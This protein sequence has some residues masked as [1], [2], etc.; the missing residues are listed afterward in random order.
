MGARRH[1]NAR[2]LPPGAR[3]G[4]Y[5]P[6]IDSAEHPP[7]LL[8]EP[9]LRL[10]ES[11]RHLEAL[12]LG[13]AMRMGPEPCYMIRSIGADALGCPGVLFVSILVHGANLI[14]QC[15]FEDDGVL[16]VR[17]RVLHSLPELEELASV[18]TARVIAG[19]RA[20]AFAPPALEQA[21]EQDPI[22]VM[23]RVQD[24]YSGMTSHHPLLASTAAGLL[25]AH[26]DLRTWRQS[27]AALVAASADEL[28]HTLVTLS[29]VFSAHVSAFLDDVRPPPV[30]EVVLATH[31]PLRQLAL[32]PRLARPGTTLSSIPAL[33][34]IRY[35]RERQ[36]RRAADPATRGH[37]RL[38]LVEELSADGG[39]LDAQFGHFAQHFD[40]VRRLPTHA[41][42][43]EATFERLMRA[44]I[45]HIAAHGENTFDVGAG[46][47]HR[48][49]RF[50]PANIHDMRAEWE[51]RLVSILSCWSAD[52]SGDLLMWDSWMESFPGIL[53]AAGVGHV[54][55]VHWRISDSSAR[56]FEAELFGR[57]SRGEDVG[58][59]FTASLSSAS[60]T[61][62]QDLG[63][64]ELFGVGPRVLGPPRPLA[65]VDEAIAGP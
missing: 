60:G 7:V 47:G 18:W 62:A 22:S 41:E 8:G 26:C 50:S 35:L 63:S 5:L 36:R 61:S 6:A 32:R 29:E 23:R 15:A 64:L 58:P 46:V 65:G 38:A 11:G 56:F 51:A 16:I 10:I 45:V 2:D 33:Y 17:S 39:D 3:G 4:I 9:V 40:E 34:F 52:T 54:I 14:L 13:D 25:G 48:G 21:V 31:G 24:D 44:D 53:L 43:D 30:D 12:I 49:T 59:A 1:R 20:P 57:L 37:G 28:E 42:R 55:G 27:D 19:L